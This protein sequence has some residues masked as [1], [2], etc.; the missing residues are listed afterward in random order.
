MES[1]VPFSI[2]WLMLSFPQALAVFKF[3]STSLTSS[4]VTLMS[5]RLLFALKGKVGGHYQNHWQTK[6]ST[7]IYSI[8]RFFVCQIC[9][10]SPI[11]LSN[12]GGRTEAVQ[13]PFISR[14]IKDQYTFASFF[15]FYQQKKWIAHPHILPYY[16]L[17]FA[18]LFIYS[19]DVGHF[20]PWPLYAT[21]LFSSS[22]SLIPY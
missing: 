22:P 15:K 8:N 18:V 4:S 5:I 17:Y 9:S 13:V 14:L 20:S 12:K 3:F 7:N 1:V 16:L 6:W 10:I 19:R 21:D 11:A 2:W